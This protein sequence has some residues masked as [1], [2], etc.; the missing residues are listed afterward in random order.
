MWKIYLGGLR[1]KSHLSQLYSCIC[2]RT[3]LK[4]EG[5]RYTSPDLGTGRLII[6]KTHAILH[7]CQSIIIVCNRKK[8]GAIQCVKWAGYIGYNRCMEAG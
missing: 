7:Y 1:F 4:T 2:A 8:H 6:G 3:V 5:S